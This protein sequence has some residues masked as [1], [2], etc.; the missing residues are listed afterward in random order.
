MNTP[1]AEILENSHA[2]RLCNSTADVI[3]PC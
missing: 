1:A 2:V 3:L